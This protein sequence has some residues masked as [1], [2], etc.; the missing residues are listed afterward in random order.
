MKSY[1]EMTPEEKAEYKRRAKEGMSKLQSEPWVTVRDFDGTVHSIP[2]SSY[3]AWKKRD[4]ELS[5]QRGLEISARIAKHRA[6][7]LASRPKIEDG[8]TL[9]ELVAGNE[10]MQIIVNRGRMQGL[11]DE[12]IWATID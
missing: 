2:A 10:H 3:E 9:D 7:F 12:E 1:F 5:H 8:K 4:K 11:S 6:E